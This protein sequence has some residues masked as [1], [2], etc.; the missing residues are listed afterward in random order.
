MNT[1]EATTIISNIFS[2][3][4]LKI[5]Q[6]ELNHYA[7]NFAKIAEQCQLLPLT[8]LKRCTISLGTSEDL[9]KLI[10]LLPNVEDLN[11]IFVQAPI[12]SDQKLSSIHQS[13]RKLEKFAM[14]CLNGSSDYLWMEQ[15][16]VNLPKSFQHLSLWFATED[17]RCFNGQLIEKLLSEHLP[18]LKKFEYIV[19][20]NDYDQSLKPNEILDSFRS[21]YWIDENKWYIACFKD[22]HNQFIIWTAASNFNNV[23]TTQPL[24]RTQMLITAPSL[25]IFY[26]YTKSWS[27]NKQTST[28]DVIYFLHQ[29]SNTR[30][31]HLDS[32]QGQ[33]TVKPPIVDTSL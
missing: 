19:F 5:I 4:S 24:L 17:N 28:E 25:K 31:L 21:S 18:K 10:E 2:K 13:M 30:Q 29:G 26:K 32:L 20:C 12:F 16:V 23:F 33:Y 3:Q 22:Q 9:F 15:L 11:L 8:N 27:F 14:K 7:F 6:L 1:N